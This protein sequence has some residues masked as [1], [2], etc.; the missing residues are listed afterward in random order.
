[1]SWYVCRFGNSP[2]NGYS[3]RPVDGYTIGG[4]LLRVSRCSRLYVSAF[5]NSCENG[6][7]S[8]TLEGYGTSA[9]IA[10][11]AAVAS[12]ATIRVLAIRFIV[13][14][15]LELIARDGFPARRP[16]C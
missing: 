13:I 5:G 10:A 16:S 9:A 15:C 1:M 8:G 14:P 12:V 11:V 4:W 3:C 6:T 7:S 2:D